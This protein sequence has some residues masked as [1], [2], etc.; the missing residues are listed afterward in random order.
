MVHDVFVMKLTCPAAARRLLLVGVPATVEHANPGDGSSDTR[1]SARYVA[2]TV[3]NFITIMDSLRLNMVAVDQIHPLLSDLIQSLNKI[4]NLPSQF[5]PKQVI[6]NWLITLNK[7]SA[8][9]ELS[10]E[11][12]RQLLFELERAHADFYQSLSR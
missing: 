12:S 7:M 10:Q 3:Q 8:S 6:K 2:E 4:P 1:Q 11:Q 9:Q 5:E